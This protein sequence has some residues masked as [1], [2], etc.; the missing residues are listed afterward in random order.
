MSPP[1]LDLLE[2]QE[3]LFEEEMCFSYEI[4]NFMVLANYWEDIRH[5]PFPI[6]QIW[7]IRFDGAKSRYGLGA[8]VVLT[9]PTGEKTLYFF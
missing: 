3:Q 4:G 7:K 9:S 2:T 5:H 6:N 8:G 1:S